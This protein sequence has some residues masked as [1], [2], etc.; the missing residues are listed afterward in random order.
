MRWVHD[1]GCDARHLER[2]FCAAT[3]LTP[4]RYARIIRFK[5]SYHDLLSRQPGSGKRHR[6]AQTHL[7]GFCD[8]SHFNKEF[9]NFVGAAPSARLRAAEA[10]ATSISD[11]LFA[12]ELSSDSPLG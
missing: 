4:K 9:R 6:A 7:A 1:E 2:R 10:P 8:Q 3:G 11:H 5:H 12:F